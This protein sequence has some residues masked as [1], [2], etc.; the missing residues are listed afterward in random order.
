VDR[1]AEENA[2]QQALSV[3]RDSPAL[4][5]DVTRGT[6]RLV[7]AMYDMETGTVRFFNLDGNPDRVRE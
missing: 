1:L 3:L 7:Y 5:A 4:K 6:A 2:R